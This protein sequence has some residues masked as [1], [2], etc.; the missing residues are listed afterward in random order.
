MQHQV[1]LVGISFLEGS[2][3]SLGID[4]LQNG[5]E[6]VERFLEDLVPVSLSHVDDDWDK[7]GEGVAL[8]SLEDVE[9]I[10]ILEKAHCSVGNLKM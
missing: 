6:G 1:D 9:E 7:K 5:L 8:V 10:V 3:E 2:L 4:F